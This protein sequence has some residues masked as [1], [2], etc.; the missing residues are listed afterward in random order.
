[1]SNLMR[2][3]LSAHG[4]ASVMVFLDEGADS[5]AAE[6]MLG[7][8]VHS[9]NSQISA[10][11]LAAGG[12]A[13]DMVPP[14]RYYPNL[15]VMLG[16]V[17]RE[18][19]KELRSEG[20]VDKVVGTPRIS[21]IKPVERR[22]TR[23]KAET[24][25]GLGAMGIRHL[26]DQG[27][28]GSGVKVAHLDTGVDAK[29]P[30]LK[31]AV[32]G[33][34]EFDSFGRERNP[35]PAPWDSGDHGTH[36]AA[37]IAG[38]PSGG[39]HVGVA[40]GAEL[41][42]AMVVEGGDVVA[43]VLGG[44]DW[45]VGQDVRILSMSLGF[46]GWWDDFLGLT[47]ILRQRGVLPVIATGNEGPGTSRSPGNYSEALSVGSCDRHG[48]VSSFSSSDRFE[49]KTDPFVPDLV[50]PGSDVVS[51]KPKGGYQTMSGT[52]MATPHV[53]GLAALLW[54]SKPSATLQDVERAIRDSCQMLPCSPVERQGRG[55]PDGPRAL[56]L[57]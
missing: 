41:Y 21:L 7:H 45:A 24:T 52:S 9:E 33:F 23:H 1:M 55:L 18:T 2:T 57:L 25:W 32:A 47:Q 39:R 49:R 6:K 26:W 37:T 36:T 13:R 4:V 17:T 50:A 40:P 31:K 14:A 38:R 53:A 48:C 10:L 46:P 11:A 20:V 5:R 19:V 22:A 35:A 29:H 51:A 54:Q 12:N 34:A 56:S 3:D 42:S 44:M 30:A 43:R 28:D 27:L 8:F 16:N 15:N